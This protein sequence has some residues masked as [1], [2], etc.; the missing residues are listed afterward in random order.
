MSN[1][2]ATINRLFTHDGNGEYKGIFIFCDLCFWFLYLF[3]S[4]T[5][6]LLSSFHLVG[7]F[8]GVLVLKSFFVLFLFLSSIRFYGPSSVGVLV[9]CFWP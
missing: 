4:I 6:A 1:H 8:R 7:S 2:N 5:F 3:I 9:L